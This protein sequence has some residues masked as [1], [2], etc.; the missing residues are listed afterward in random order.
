MKQISFREI[1]RQKNTPAFVV[2]NGIGRKD[3]D[4]SQLKGRGI[5][6]GCNKLGLEYDFTGYPF[7]L[8]SGDPDPLKLLYQQNYCGS[9]ILNTVAA[10]QPA[11]I[12]H[13]NNAIV[14]DTASAKYMP[15]S[16]NI[17]LEAAVQLGC[18]PVIIL[19][20]M[21]TFEKISNYWTDNMYDQKIHYKNAEKYR[22]YTGEQIDAQRTKLDNWAKGFFHTIIKN[23]QILFAKVSGTSKLDLPSISWEDITTNMPAIYRSKSVDIAGISWPVGV[24]HDVSLAQPIEAPEGQA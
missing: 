18:N 13:V 1:P 14:F 3:L 21:N 6:F 11:R 10:K 16:G 5:V 12:A 2:G 22:L 8:I 24:T 17:A 19:G 7:H 20:I 15:S 23:P 4:I 9:L